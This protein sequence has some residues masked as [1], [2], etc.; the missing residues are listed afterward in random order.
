MIGRSEAER[1]R[2]W[3][4]RAH[5][6]TAESLSHCIMQLGYHHILIYC[7]DVRIFIALYVAVF[8]FLDRSPTMS[9]RRLHFMSQS[10]TYRCF[11]SVDSFSQKEISCSLLG[12]GSHSVFLTRIPR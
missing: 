8:H 6:F 1:L 2:S 7:I 11:I 12:R 4:P 3:E 9:V 5:P 10:A